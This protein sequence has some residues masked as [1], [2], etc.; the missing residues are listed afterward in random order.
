MQAFIG[1]ESELQL[2]SD[3]LDSSGPELVAV[4]GRRRV[5]KTFLIRHAYE[6]QTVFEFSGIKDTSA[7]Q[8]LERFALALSKAFKLE[9][10][11]N[12]LRSWLEAFSLLSRCW[13]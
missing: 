3:V 2:L 12:K 9:S 4:F 10:T 1:R 8:Q 7:T 11:P 5:G 6:K 13:F